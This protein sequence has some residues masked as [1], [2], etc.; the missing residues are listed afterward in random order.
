MGLAI[1]ERLIP[2]WPTVPAPVPTPSAAAVGA[3]GLGWPHTG[4]YPLFCSQL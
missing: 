1:C 3:P 4:R 2:A